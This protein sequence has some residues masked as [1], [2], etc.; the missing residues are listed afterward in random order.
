MKDRW[1]AGLVL[2]SL[3]VWADL[4]AW[5][6]E[7]LSPQS[8]TFAQASSTHETDVSASHHA[9]CRGLK[10]D[11]VLQAT[12]C[13]GQHLCCFSQAPDDPSSLPVS[14]ETAV[15]SSTISRGD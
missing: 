6:G 13:G 3:F 15:A 10:S 2:C 11:F 5:S 12:P 8:A 14:S 4:P 1:I 7:R 9:C